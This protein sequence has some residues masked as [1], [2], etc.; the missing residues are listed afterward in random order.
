MLFSGIFGDLSRIYVDRT[1]EDA[2]AP[3]R[4]KRLYARQTSFKPDKIDDQ[5]GA[6]AK[7][8]DSPGVWLWS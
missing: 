5:S 7:P 2:K 1:I 3:N 4:S 8:A 6:F